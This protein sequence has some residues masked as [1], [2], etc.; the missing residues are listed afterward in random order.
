LTDIAVI[1]TPTDAGWACEVR[2]SD[3]GRVVGRHDVRVSRAELASLAPGAPEPVELVRRSFE[4]LLERESPA[5]IL[6][7]FDLSTIARYFPDY[8]MEIARRLS[9]A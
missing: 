7:S 2:L 9:A 8:P 6:R 4:F 1:A 3:A 5:S